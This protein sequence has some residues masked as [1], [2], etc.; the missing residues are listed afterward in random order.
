[1]VP[2]VGGVVQVVGGGTVRERWGQLVAGRGWS[3]M[4]RRVPEGG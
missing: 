4:G 3:G 2:G 1:M